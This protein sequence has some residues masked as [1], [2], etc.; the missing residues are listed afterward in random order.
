MK[1]HI[2]APVAIAPL[3]SDNKGLVTTLINTNRTVKCFRITTVINK[4]KITGA[5]QRI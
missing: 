5:E 4:D 3:P 1:V 2:L